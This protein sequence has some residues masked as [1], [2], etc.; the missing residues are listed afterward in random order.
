MKHLRFYDLQFNIWIKFCAESLATRE[1]LEKKG[2]KVRTVSAI[3]GV[4]F[5]LKRI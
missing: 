5:N 1:L 3:C 2:S 4:G